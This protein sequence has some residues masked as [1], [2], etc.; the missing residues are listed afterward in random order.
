M[1]LYF[2]TLTFLFSMQ[3]FS[4]VKVDKKLYAKDLNNADLYFETED[5]VNA[6]ST[7]KKV[8]AIDP[9]HEKANLNSAISR[10][11]LGQP[12]DSCYINLE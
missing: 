11:K 9:N 5:Y 12:T 6:I 2:Y 4:Q 1:K 8:L 3:V 7:Y 10:I